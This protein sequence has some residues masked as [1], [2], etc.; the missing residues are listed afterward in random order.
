MNNYAYVTLLYPNKNKK[1]TYLDGTILMAL[2]LRKQNTKHKLICMVTDD[3]SEHDTNILK[4]LYDEIKVV[5]CI[6]PLDTGIKIQKDIFEI[7]VFKDENNYTDMCKVFTKLHIFD[8]NKFPYEKIIFV[9]NDII[10]LEKYDDLFDLDVPAAWLEKVCEFTNK[11]GEC[12]YNRI[13]GTYDDIEHGSIIPR[14]FTD[15]FKIP[16]RG[17]NGGL[18]VIKPNV[19]IFNFMINQL[20]TDTKL[21]IGNDFL[22]KGVINF[23]KK[24]VMHFPLYEQDYLTQLFSGS[25]KMIDGRYCAWGDN[26]NCKIYG[27]HMA[28]LKYLINGVW[29]NNKAWQVQLPINDGFNVVTNKIAIWGINKY[30]LKKILMKDLNFYIDEKIIHIDN[31]NIDDTYFNKLSLYQKLLILAIKNDNE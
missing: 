10:P 15:T 12:F 21:W 26:H 30:N 28:G 1:C 20:Q 14:K 31:I 8:S 24:L 29:K 6:S 7:N 11:S 17:I 19:E 18:I 4:M 16:G 27:M 2:G 13:W 23:D 9:D 22:H 25:W 3:V 5:D